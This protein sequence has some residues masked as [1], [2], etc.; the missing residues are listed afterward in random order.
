M[1]RSNAI[2]VIIAVFIAL[3]FIIFKDVG[4]RQLNYKLCIVSPGKG[5]F[6]TEQGDRV[7][8]VNAKNS[9]IIKKKKNEVDERIILSYIWI[10]NEEI[11]VKTKTMESTKIYLTKDFNNYKLINEY[12]SGQYAFTSPDFRTVVLKQDNQEL[13]IQFA[14]GDIWHTGIVGINGYSWSNDGVY[15]MISTA[16]GK[17]LINTYAQLIK[18]IDKKFA[19]EWAPTENKYVFY[20]NWDFRGF[21]ERCLYLFDPETLV[22]SKVNLAGVDYVNSYVWSPNSQYIAIKDY[23]SIFIVSTRNPQDPPSKIHE[24]EENENMDKFSGLNWTKDSKGITFVSHKPGWRITKPMNFYANKVDIETGKSKQVY[25]A[26][27]LYDKIYW[28]D[29]NVLYY[30]LDHKKGLFRKKLPW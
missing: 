8:L 12:K 7:L 17:Y 14:K 6:I 29:D 24:F 26:G 28:A 27:R 11:A 3:C 15:L 30:E 10:N 23:D 21:E 16:N 2:Y 1:S 19:G 25:I 4:V 22:F 9:R 13:V 5:K 20:T 18:K